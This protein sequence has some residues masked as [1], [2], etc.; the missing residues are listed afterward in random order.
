MNKPRAHIIWID[1]EIDHLK[2]HIISLKDKGYDVTPISN[3]WD[4][5]AAVKENNFD[6]VLLDHFMSGLD[7]IET[8]R[9]IKEIKS[10]LPVVMITKSEEEWLMDE[11]ISE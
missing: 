9:K 4:G 3:G 2:S 6:L 11:A 1:D 8:L 5:I 10:D 7:G